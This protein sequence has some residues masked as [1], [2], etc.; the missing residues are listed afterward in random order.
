MI[1][2]TGPPKRI[3]LD[4][5]SSVDTT[6]KSRKYAQFARQKIRSTAQPTLET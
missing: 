3:T 6:N 4:M 5:D 1:H 2:A